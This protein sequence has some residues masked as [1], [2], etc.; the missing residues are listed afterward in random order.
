MDDMNNMFGFVSV[1]V[2]G[3]GIYALYAYFKMKKDGHINETLLLGKS[4]SEYM[5]KDKE[6]FLGKS[7][8]AVLAFAVVSLVY[9]AIDVVHCYVRPLGMIDVVSGV[10]FLAV[11]IWYMVYTTKLKKKYF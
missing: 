7:L 6:A 2:L 9:G 10:I 11:V 4:Y 1:M 5:C 8:P 3:C